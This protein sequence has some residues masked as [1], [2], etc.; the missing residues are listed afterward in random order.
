M[1]SAMM[2][3][4]IL[5]V[6]V[7]VDGDISQVGMYDLSNASNFLWNGDILTGTKVGALLTINQNDIKII[8]KVSKEAVIDQ[9]NTVKSVQFDNRY[10]ENSVNRIVTVKTQG[11]II[12]HRFQVTR[13]YVPM[14]GNEVTVTEKKDLDSILGISDSDAA[15]S[16][17]KSILEKQRIDLP[18][19]DFFASHIGIFGNTGSGKSNT[20]HK[21]YLELFRWA[22]KK[23]IY[24]NLVAKSKFFVIDFNGEYT[25]EKTFGV[26]VED[27]RIFKI[28]TRHPKDS[29]KIPVKKEYLFNADILSILFDAKPG[30]Q[31]PFL[32]SAMNIF[33]TQLIE[34]DKSTAEEKFSE[35][36][37]GLLV[38]IFK[39]YKNI[40]AITIKQ[41]IDAAEHF[42]VPKSELG[43]ISVAYH[44][45]YGNASLT[46]D[47]DNEHSATIFESGKLT[48]EGEKIIN[49]L[50]DMLTEN[51]QKSTPITQLKVFL[52]FQA[53]YATAWET[54]KYDYLRPLIKR[55]QTAFTSL[56]NTITLVEDIKDEY[57]CMNI[58]CL[59]HANQEMKRLIPMLVSKMLYDE[60]KENISD[61]DIA[62]QTRH[63]IIDEAHNILNDK[64]RND[65]DSWQDY[66]LSIFEEIIKEGRKFGFYLALAS[67]RPADISPTIMSQL[68]NY[69][70]HRLVNENDWSVVK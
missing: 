14:I 43:K 39:D 62:N 32:R 45:D 19:N 61:V 4:K 54:I 36:E 2:N 15:I 58:F 42:G 7:A 67:Q 16:I 31:I 63:L 50:K 51:Y 24:K 18:V 6:I 17:G 22:K 65:G 27:K 26:D 35:L 52:E 47:Q 68:H 3:H 20:L 12:D 25:G 53:I 8:A 55:M 5:G 46:Q 38:A 40:N 64:Y 57:K 70:I 49:K 33:N 66:R 1:V 28:D 13:E 23:K 37:C 11:V 69:F 59:V 9:Q 10:K 44:L 21:L 34:S 30:T 60:Q 48:S 56:A 29:E 41:W